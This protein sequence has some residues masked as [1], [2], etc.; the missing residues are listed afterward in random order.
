MTKLCQRIYEEDIVSFVQ[1]YTDHETYIVIIGDCV[2]Y[3]KSRT[4][5]VLFIFHVSVPYMIIVFPAAYVQYSSGGYSSE[6][7]R[8]VWDEHD[9]AQFERKRIYECCVCPRVPQQSAGHRKSNPIIA[10]QYL[11]TVKKLKNIF[12]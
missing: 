11:A 7:R 1:K 12:S 6:A 9:F 2:E 10:R 5:L 8:S 3:L 4:A